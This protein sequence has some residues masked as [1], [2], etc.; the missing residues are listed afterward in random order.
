MVE[1]IRRYRMG[2]EVEAF[3]ELLGRIGSIFL[4]DKIGY[5]WRKC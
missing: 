2:N 5:F 4:L 1:G 3:R